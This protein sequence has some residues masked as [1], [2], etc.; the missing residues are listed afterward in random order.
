MTHEAAITVL[1][2]AKDVCDTNRPIN[3]DRGNTEQAELERTNSIAYGEAIEALKA[4]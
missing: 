1:Q 4:A 2:I 3:L